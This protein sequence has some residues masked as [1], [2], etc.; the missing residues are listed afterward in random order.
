LRSLANTRLQGYTIIYKTSNNGGEYV[1]KP[2]NHFRNLSV[3]SKFMLAYVAILIIPIMFTA[4]YLYMQETNAALSDAN[5]LMEQ[6]LFQIKSSILQK[7]KIIENMAQIVSSDK[8]IETFL[9]NGF[10]E[11]AYSI[12]D[13]RYNI[14]PFVDNIL[15]QSRQLFSIRIYMANSTIPEVYDSFYNIKR[16]N[17]KQLYRELLTTPSVRSKWVTSHESSTHVLKSNKSNKEEVVSFCS[18][19]NSFTDNYL[20]G[21]LEIEVKENSLF[22]VLRDPVNSKLGKVFIVD[23]NGTVVSNNIPKYYKKKIPISNQDITKLA[24]L[25][26]IEEF[27]GVKSMIISVPVNEIGCSIM[28]VF[29]VDNFT[30]KVKGS[31]TTIVFVS[32]LSVLFLGCIF[33]I[34]TNT[35]LKRIKILVKAMKEVRDGNLSV[36]VEVSSKDEFGKLGL[37]FN[38]MTERIHDL[39]ETVYKSQLMEREAE[40]RALQAQINPHF[41]YNTLATISWVARKDNSPE[42]DKIATSLAK[43]YRLVLNKGDILIGVKEELEMV[44][45][46][47][48]I[49]KIR[50]ENMFDVVYNIDEIPHNTQIVKNILQPLVENALIHGIEPMRSHGTIIIKASEY[51]NKLLLQ[52]I[53]DGAGMNSDTLKEILEGKVER[54][55]GS[56]YALKNI[57]KRLNAFYGSKYSFDIFSELDIGTCISIRIDIGDNK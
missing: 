42:I 9:E 30:E 45:A 50:F 13:Y 8:R 16:V 23:E 51:E 40:L 19:I 7:V 46:Y 44:K 36:S 26:K 34:L 52:V 5:M 3:A 27:E 48:D 25:N 18:K 1:K 33:Y 22:D 57:M 21:L 49:Q 20:V 53:D 35:L 28:G 6:N 39:V 2:I 4:T 15:R 31:I 43:F 29:P 37:S 12:N 41:L 17:E 54:S 56:G 47:L 11:D 38:N 32:S 14:I 55:Q 10:E 24:T